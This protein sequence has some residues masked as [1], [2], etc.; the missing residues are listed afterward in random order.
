MT[1]RFLAL[2]G[3]IVVQ[4]EGLLILLAIA[5]WNPVR[6]R[7]RA[8]WSDNPADERPANFSDF[9]SP[10]RND[11]FRTNTVQQYPIPPRLLP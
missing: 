8:P 10:S 7:E 4:R 6:L 9:R 5:R 3:S 11:T 2:N 1:D